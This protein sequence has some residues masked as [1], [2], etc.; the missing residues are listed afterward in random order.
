MTGEIIQIN[1]SPG[2]IP[3]RAVSQAQI[4]AYGIEG[5]SWAHP[6][7][8]GGP[9]KAI[10]LMDA[11]GIDELARRGYPVYY[12]ALGENLTVR[13]LDRRGLRTGQQLRA[14]TALLELTRIRVPCST[15][16]VYGAAIQREIYDGRVKAG[17]VSSPRW[18]MS[19]FYA[20]VLQPGIVRVKDIICVVATLA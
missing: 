7:I 4:T 5:D 9:D 3:K 12:G 11:D 18:G 20:R 13:G 8:H 6:R 14:G 17:D 2:G 15:L 1:V 16:D 10:L 19:G